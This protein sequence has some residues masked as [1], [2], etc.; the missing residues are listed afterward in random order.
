MHSST[1]C[2]NDDYAHP[3]PA[4]IQQYA[5][6]YT[7]THLITILTSIKPH[8]HSNDND[9]NNNNDDN[10]TSDRYITNDD[11][12]NNTVRRHDIITRKNT[13]SRH[14]CNHSQVHIIDQVPI[15][16]SRDREIDREMCDF[17][18]MVVVISNC[19]SFDALT[20]ST[21]T[22]NTTDCRGSFRVVIFQEEYV[23][24]PGGGGSPYFVWYIVG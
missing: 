16:P 14:I 1:A 24:F 2:T 13:P 17:F 4:N 8:K 7:H 15:S 18:H 3:P 12:K 9:N 21:T 5:C 19:Q 6:I 23:V 11:G 20:F 22:Y 10:K